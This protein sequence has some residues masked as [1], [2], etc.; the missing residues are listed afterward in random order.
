MFP[1][2]GTTIYDD[3]VRQPI[4]KTTDLLPTRRTTLT[5]MGAPGAT[6]AAGAAG[7]PGSDGTPG[8][9][10]SDGTPGTP[11]EPGTDGT[12]GTPGQDGTPG[13]NGDPGPPGPKDS[14]LKLGHD[15]FRAVA[16][17]ESNQALLISMVPFG[18]PVPELF[19]LACGGKLTR[20]ASPDFMFE[21]WVGVREDQKDWNM[22]ARTE[23]QYLANQKMLAVIFPQPAIKANAS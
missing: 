17:V 11:G 15:T 3:R 12:P 18:Q 1:G 8:T 10:G 2:P 7:T 5:Q 9:P 13:Q 21:L 14:I 16:C 6:G 22:P 19:R 4:I 23:E 20:F